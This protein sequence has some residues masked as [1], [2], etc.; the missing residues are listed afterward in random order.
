MTTVTGWSQELGRRLLADLLETMAPAAAGVAVLQKAQTVSFDGRASI[1]APGIIAGAGSAS[2]VVEGA[3]TPVR[4]LSVSSVTLTPAKITAPY[5]L[6]RELLASSNAEQEIENALLRSMRARIDADL[7]STTA[8]APG[9]P[10]GLRAGITGL[11][12]T[13]G[14]GLN[15]MISDVGQVCAGPTSVSQQN[16]VLVADTMAATS[17]GLLASPK[18]PVPVYMTA[19]G[20]GLPNHSLMCVG[21]DGLLCAMDAD[22]IRIDV[23]PDTSVHME[24]VPVDIGSPGAPPVVAAPAKSM[25]QTDSLCVRL[26]MHLTWALRS[27]TAVSWL[28]PTTW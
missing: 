18:F 12:P 23:S 26:S 16:I 8:A 9:R 15:A 6:T 7:F 11:T 2:Y 19:S 20:V 4:M 1:A 27:L 25:Y 28:S 10:G 22:S 17:M 3:A 14:G 5:V 13:A 21:L 24:D